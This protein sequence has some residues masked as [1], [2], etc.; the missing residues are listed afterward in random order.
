MLWDSH[1]KQK[2][3]TDRTEVIQRRTGPFKLSSDD[4]NS[5][6][7]EMISNLEW[8]SPPTPHTS[9]L[10]L[11][12]VQD[13]S[14][15]CGQ[16]LIYWQSCPGCLKHSSHPWCSDWLLIADNLLCPFFLLLSESIALFQVHALLAGEEK[17]RETTFHWSH[18]PDGPQ[19]NLW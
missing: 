5:D 15:I 19:T 2:L 12:D 14:S 7:W 16:V 10:T 13:L 3:N 17:A 4:K 18:E 6:M 9:C 1:T 8:P 11:L